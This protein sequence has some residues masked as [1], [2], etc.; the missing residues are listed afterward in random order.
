MNNQN[1][2]EKTVGDWLS[3]QNIIDPDEYSTAIL[4]PKEFSIA[5]SLKKDANINEILAVSDTPNNP[6]IR[7]IDGVSQYEFLTHELADRLQTQ[8]NLEYGWAIADDTIKSLEE[9]LNLEEAFSKI[10][11]TSDQFLSSGG[12]SV[13]NLESTGSRYQIPKDEDL[14]AYENQL[15]FGRGLQE[16]LEENYGGEATLYEGPEFRTKDPHLIWKKPE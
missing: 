13:Y 16:V 7:G 12:H 4:W 11:K 10:A 3:E 15:S 2:G 6:V 8:V 5:N 1:R 14:T 9:G